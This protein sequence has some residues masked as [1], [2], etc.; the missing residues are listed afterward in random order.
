MPPGLVCPDCDRT[1]DAGPRE[2]WRCV[3]GSPLELDA[4]LAPGTPPAQLDRDRG[5]WAF[6]SLIPVDRRVTLGE[7]FTPLVEAPNW[8]ASFKLEYVFP[9]GSFKDRGATTILSRAAALG[10]DRVI[11]DSSGNA[12]AAIALYAARAGIPADIYVPEGIKPAKRAAIAG[13]GATV[14]EV[15]GT[16]SAVSE[17]AR[18]A[19]ESGPGWYASHAW[20][21]AFYAGTAT[22]AYEIA[23]NRDFDL[24]EAIVAP[25][26]HG[27][28]YLG[29]YRGFSTLRDAGWI[30]E[31]PRLLGVQATGVAPIATALGADR[32]GAPRND[33][34]DG[35]QIA[36]PVRAGEIRRA[37]RATAGDVVAVDESATR[38]AWRA[39]HRAG[40]HVEP[41][42]AVAVAGLEAFRERGLDPAADIVVPLTGSGLKAGP[43]ET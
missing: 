32:S 23:V 33:L 27:T 29:L 5:L 26:G 11:E 7:G 6:D 20:N 12:G 21:P 36:E 16:R 31:L 9:S 1:Y 10:V 42:S 19:A 35:I 28:L 8:D 4:T 22:V 30:D 40:F 2:P 18:E 37:V 17:A 3:C 38:S 39:L 41:T 14:R 43:D 25:I 13:T 15:S 34:A 24:P